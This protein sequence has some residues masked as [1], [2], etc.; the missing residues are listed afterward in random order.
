MA[1]TTDYYD[2]PQYLMDLQKHLDKVAPGSLIIPA[3]LDVVVKEYG[4]RPCQPH[5]QQQYT[6]ATFDSHVYEAATVGAL[7]ILSEHIIVVDIDDP[8]LVDRFMEIFPAAMC[9]VSAKT[10]KGRHFYFRSTEYSKADGIKDGGRQLNDPDNPGQKLPIDIKTMSSTGVGGLISI[11]PSKNKRWHMSPL[12]Y[13]MTDIPKDFVDFYKKYHKDAN[14]NKGLSKAQIGKF[15]N[16][17]NIDEVK[18]LLDILDH[19]RCDEYDDWI[20]V[21][22]CLHNTNNGDDMLN[23]WDSWSEKS[24]KYNEGECHAKW[25]TFGEHENKLTLGSLH[26]WAKADNTGGYKGIM[27][28]RIYNDIIHFNGQHNSMARIASKV[29]RG[30]F[31]CA[32]ADG[33]AWYMFNGTLWIPDDNAIKLRSELSS[34]MYEH[35]Y[36]VYEKLN[37]E[38]KKKKGIKPDNPD[39]EDDA[40]SVCES[41]ASTAVEPAESEVSIEDLAK[42]M[43][44]YA[45]RLQD[46]RFKD[47]VTTEMREF[48][49][50]VEFEAKLDS[51]I[52]LIAFT[53]GVYDLEAGRFREALPEDYCSISVGY[54]YIPEMNT[55]LRAKVEK[56]W[57][58][59]HPNE[60]QR[61]Y[62]VKM[63]ARQLYGDSGRELF[64]V[65][66]GHRGQAANGKSTFFSNMEKALGQYVR[67]TSV[68]IL[69]AKS[70]DEA[71]RP[72]PEYAYWRG[73]RILYVS[74][75]EQSECL[76]S[77]I[78]KDLTGGER[79]SYRL[80][81]S[82]K[83]V[84]FK[85]QFKIAMQCNDVPKLDATDDGMKRRM[86]KIDYISRFVEANEVDEENHKYPIDPS[87]MK[88]LDSSDAMKME[89][90]RYLLDHFSLEYNFEMPES[91]RRACEC[92]LRDND[93]VAQFVEEFVEPSSD[94]DSYFTLKAARDLFS[95]QDY[96][97]GRAT[98]LK[99]DLEKMLKTTCVEQKRINKIRE[100]NVF[101]GFTLNTC[102]PFFEAD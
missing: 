91:I 80:L 22:M 94:K 26:A 81:Y 17:Y 75:P 88:E 79:I 85:P 73:R 42:A 13:N 101:L 69:T 28:A 78:V 92:Y 72:Q 97:N 27:R 55:E 20:K 84:T 63:F 74:E 87:F 4:K 16:M 7:I 24:L 67:K 11:P 82:N 30:K 83:I 57:N 2:S 68:S 18:S 77:G 61:S 8:K 44:T 93:G 41:I 51:N 37:N 66:A 56:Y 34:T 38:V 71:S 96:Y 10:S 25:R 19:N 14:I 70:R 47:F 100:K 36:A 76:H 89:F 58:V 23:L 32:S 12:K 59:L 90:L 21:G 86:R 49:L 35:F 62:V 52:N 60:D 98:T 3:K 31:V 99:T 6:R 46:K 64:H 43:K 15:S 50:D 54:D 40:Q 33:S 1:S 102:D 53:N 39:T 9:T 48:L 5:A 95:R 45:N 29:L 65:H